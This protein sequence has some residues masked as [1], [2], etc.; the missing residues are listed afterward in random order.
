MFK[1]KGIIFFTLVIMLMASSCSGPDLD[2]PLLT[3]EVPLH[4][5]EHLDDARIEGSAVGEDF[6]APVEWHFDEPQPDWKPIISLEASFKPARVTYIGDALRITLS[7][8]NLIPRFQALYGGIFTDLPKWHQEDWHSILVSART[9]DDIQAIQLV[10]NFQEQPGPPLQGRWLFSDACELVEDGSVHTY[11]LKV[12]RAFEWQ[13][14][15]DPLLEKLCINVFANEPANV[16]IL[17]VKAIPRNSLYAYAPFGL[18]TEVS[19]D[20]FHRTL[21][22]HTPGKFGYRIKV[23][24]AGQLDVGLGVL[25][26]DIPLTF[27][28]KAIPKDGEEETLLEEIYSDSEHWAQRSVDLSNLEGQTITLELESEAERPGNVSFWAAPTLSGKRATKEPNIIF[29][30]IDGASADYMSVYGYNRRTTPNLER[31]AAEGAVFEHAYSNA[32]WTKVSNPS[33]MTSLYSSVLGGYTSETGQLPDQAITMAQLMHSS[34]YQTG[35][36]TTNPYC[37]TMS[38]FDRGVDWLREKG[39]EDNF[40]SSIELHKDFWEWRAA[41]PGEPYWVHFQTTDIHWPFKP[42]APFAGLYLS[43]ELR[44]RYYEWE[45]QVTKAAGVGRAWPTPRLLTPDAFKKA[46]INHLEYFEAARCLYDEAMAHNDYQIG[47]LVERLKSSGEWENTLFIIAA[48]H[49]SEHGLGLYD[50]IPPVWGPLFRSIRTRIP[51]IFIWPEH[52]ASGL[53]LR[54]PVSMI[55]MLPTILDLAGLPAPVGLQGQSLA[56]LLLGEE[57]WHPRPVVFDEFYFDQ[58]TRKLMGKIEVIDGRWGA[59]LDIDPSFGKERP[60]DYQPGPPPPFPVLIYDI[61]EDP[62]CLVPL[63]ETRPDLVRKYTE[64]LEAKWK[65]HQKLAKS[66]SIS[67]DAPLTPEQIQIL[68]SLGYIR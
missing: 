2:Q 25:R 6:G 20:V 18:S 30:I 34:G 65:E 59:S 56:P 44:L 61:W 3:A 9:K 19:S 23:P 35:V 66:F 13:W 14:K 67:A 40:A 11:M 5:E 38:G 1:P 47:K 12:R 53:R 49:G 48:D 64:F 52:I 26:G 68:R 60:F 28:I 46:G 51:M 21:F 32:T 36:L 45:R 27:K 33:F 62:N 43:P 29:Y 16:D 7:K 22:M 39:K 57:G 4:L 58:E 54:Q 55:D 8:D 42:A 63:N 15:S 17:S 37:G 41:Y 50:P 31:L 24:K 10:F